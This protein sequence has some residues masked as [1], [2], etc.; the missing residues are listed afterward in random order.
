[1]NHEIEFTRFAC[2]V[3]NLFLKKKNEFFK[4]RITSNKK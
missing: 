3:L 4:C 2:Q 1:M